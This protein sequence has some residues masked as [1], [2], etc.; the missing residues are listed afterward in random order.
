MDREY[1]DGTKV[2]SLKDLNGKRPELIL[3]TTNRSG[4]KTTFFSRL[5]VN[6]FKK[7]N[8]KFCLVYRYGY[9]LDDISNKFFKDVGSLFFK[10]DI[11]ES[12]RRSQGV[13]HELFL[14]DKSCGYAIALNNAEQ[15]KKL[16]HLFSDVDYMLLDEFQS[17]TNHYCSG[18][19]KKFISIHTS[20]AR[21]QGKAVRFVPIYMLSNTVSTI[22]PYYVALKISPR[23][24][25]DTKFLRGDG[26][27]L[28]Q[29]YVDTVSKAQKESGFN[30]AFADNEYV[31]YST[32][33]VYLDDNVAFI[34][35]P[36]GRNKYLATIRCENRDY[37]IREYSELG[38]I[39]C[40]DRV[41]HTFPFK[42][43]ITTDDH[44]IN[45]V[46]LKKND[47]FL[48]NMRY[49]FERGCFRFK[50]L[51]CKEIIMQSVSY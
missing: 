48:S 5:L 38:I 20:I 37:A 45:Y 11:M 22:N 14:N 21:G 49:F 2:L 51:K 17:E 3:V 32:E 30:R 34:E 4:G 23:L 19:I 13:Y 24:R 27:V 1:Y 43:S 6:K 39:Y 29:G 12:K 26:W 41:D 44:M 10:S 16:S 50:D 35:K 15:I 47:F 40:D 18:E 31:A 46:M 28:E 7:N 9:E 36:Q 25:K 8:E 42:I 33:N